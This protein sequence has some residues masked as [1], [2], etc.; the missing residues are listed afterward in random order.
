MRPEEWEKLNRAI[1][2]DWR[3][4]D[5]TIALFET[6]M[7]LEGMLKAIMWELDIDEAA[8]AEKWAR[9]LREGEE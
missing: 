8:V 6:V 1:K 7:R 4:T 2:L 3:D 5:Q 9:K